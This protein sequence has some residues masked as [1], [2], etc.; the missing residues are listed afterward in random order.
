MSQ[1]A[2]LMKEVAAAKAFAKENL[3]Q[4]SA[5]VLSWQE[6]GVLQPNCLFAAL[7]AMCSYAGASSQRVAE[8]LVAHE[9]LALAAL[10]ASPELE[11]AA[12]D[13]EQIGDTVLHIY[14]RGPNSPPGNQRVP[15]TGKFVADYLRNLRPAQGAAQVNAGPQECQAYSVNLGGS[16]PEQ[17]WHCPACGDVTDT[18]RCP[19]GLIVPQAEINRA[20]PIE[21]GE[22]G[23]RGWIA[24]KTGHQPIH[25]GEFDGWTVEQVIGPF[26]KAQPGERGE[27]VAWQYFRL[28]S[29]CYSS[30]EVT[31]YPC[32]PLYLAP[33]A[34]AS[35][36]VL[37]ERVLW[38]RNE[39]IHPNGAYTRDFADG[40]KAI[41]DALLAEGGGR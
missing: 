40:V 13:F 37:K 5:D 7:W 3:Q 35:G 11:R 20:A 2:P 1:T 39:V 16:P 38:A 17:G 30:H 8:S 31:S 34:P 28:G 9:A 41:C 4:L 6:T 32:R 24:C 23:S 10:R 18:D 14:D 27:P 21:P 22:R 33:P 12:R 36:E 29:W 25:F 19:L 26:P 15:L